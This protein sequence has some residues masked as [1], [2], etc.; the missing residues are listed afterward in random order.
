M[1]VKIKPLRE[2][3]QFCARENLGLIRDFFFL[4]PKRK[5]QTVRQ[6]SEKS[7]R[8]KRLPYVKK[9]KK[10]PKKRFTHTFFSRTKKKH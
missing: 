9:I 2:K 7:L 4:N 10:G 3:I 6:I 8:E 5:I 1:R